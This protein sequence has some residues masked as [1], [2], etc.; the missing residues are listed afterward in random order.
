[1]KDPPAGGFRSL[2]E[3][4]SVAARRVGEREWAYVQ[5]GAEEERALKA[6]RAAFERR[7]L[8]PRLLTD[9]SSVQLAS[10]LLGAEVRFPAFV[11]PTA[12]HEFL[13]PEAEVATARAAGSSGV[14][15]AFSTLSARSLE[16]IAEAA[17]RA[18]KW[19]QLYL[20]PEF[21]AS[22]ALVERAERARYRALVLTADMPVL[23]SRDALAEEEFDIYS[24]AALGNGPSVVPPTRAPVRAPSGYS[25]GAPA[26]ATWSIVDDLISITRL[27][28]VVKG[29]LSTAD[30]E[31][32]I[33]RG[34]A[35]IVVSNH[36]GRQF[37]A[38]PAALDMLGPVARSIGDRAEVYLDGGV[39]RG[40]DLLVA[41]ASGARAVGIGRPVLWALAAGGEA[42]V[43]R[44]FDLLERE[45]A[46]AMALCG[47][48]RIAEVDS[49]LLGP[50]RTG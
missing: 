11:A 44:Y 5:G 9:V 2:G 40:S 14:L 13:N 46:T 34:A 26:S 27:P 37:D 30:A 42:G 24:K 35:G 15:A 25:L 28:V 33:A 1:M 4:E 18:P 23:A 50:L 36:G 19:F 10:T 41:L 31:R 8:V 47:C 7:T 21:S 39:R 6:N 48:R 12:H 43:M 29:V 38:A 22:R 17:P 49:T 16:E 45:F 20:Q 3:L 32:A